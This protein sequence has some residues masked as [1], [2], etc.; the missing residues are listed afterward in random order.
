MKKQ[1]GYTAAAAA[2]LLWMIL[3]L[4][5]TILSVIPGSNSLGVEVGDSFTVSP[6]KLEEGKYVM[7]ISGSLINLSDDTVMLD[8]VTFL[9]KS[10]KETHTVEYR[11]VTLGVRLPHEILI[12]FEA[13]RAYDRIEA[14]SYEVAGRSERIPDHTGGLFDLETLL[15]AFATL[16]ATLALIHFA[17]QCYY[18][19]QE[20]D[21]LHAQSKEA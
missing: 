16:I 6:S 12:D 11:D 4:V 8:K 9:V 15:C 14:I 17:K 19:K 2:S 3:F 7:Q 20:A 5:L 1:I 18:L 13:E 10:G 21:A